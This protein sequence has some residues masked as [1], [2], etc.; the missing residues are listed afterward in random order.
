MF[1]RYFRN[2]YLQQHIIFFVFALTLWIPT[3]INPP[4]IAAQSP[5]SP[6]YN[7]LIQ[8]TNS[9]LIWSILA[10][11]AILLQSL[12]FNLILTKNDYIRKTSLLGSFLYFVIMSHH[13]Y[14][15]QFS[16][17]IMSHFFILST[18]YFALN[19]YG[20]EDVIRESFRLG[21]NVGLASL[22]YLPSIFFLVLIF[23]TLLL[24]RV[25]YWRLW[26]IPVFSFLSPYIFLFTFYFATDKLYIFNSYF[27]HFLNKLT[28]SWPYNDTLSTIISI[29][30]GITLVLSFGNF[31]RRKHEKS[32][33]L[34]KKI[35]FFIYFLLIAIISVLISSESLTSFTTF[36]IPVSLIIAV[37]FND[38]KKTLWVDIFFTIILIL[39]FIN[40]Y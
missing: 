34:R 1:I 29:A 22:F 18:V 17:A 10:F 11:G 15:Q 9:K 37:Y 6:L 20:K 13:P 40:I 28:F 5:S 4:Y 30:L 7:L 27:E 2:S 25:S 26:I 19:M 35:T 36:I 33:H 31:L 39:I 23:S 38:L 21:F 14:L 3:F 32:I 24:Y 8:L 12:F 16:P